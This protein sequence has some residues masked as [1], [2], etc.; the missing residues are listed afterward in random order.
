MTEIA[1]A[2]ALVLALVFAWA[3]WAKAINRSPIVASFRG[4]GL[5]APAALAVVVPVVEATL[6]IALVLRPAPAALAAFVLLVVFSV[7]IGRAVAAGS[8]VACACFGASAGERPVSV[9]ELVRNGGLGAL[10]IVANGAGTSTALWPSVP[11]TVI[12]TVLVVV[13]RVALGAAAVR[14]QRRPRVRP[15][16]PS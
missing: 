11:A 13:G 14:R 3:A 15:A 10:A 12:V 4:L 16:P 9:L 2:S 1:Q 6:A 8:T 7:G 5:P